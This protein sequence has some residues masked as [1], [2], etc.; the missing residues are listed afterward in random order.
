MSDDE[1]DYTFAP[2]YGDKSTGYHR[3]MISV[4]EFF[5]SNT[6]KSMLEDYAVTEM[7]C[8]DDYSYAA[9]RAKTIRRNGIT[10]F[11]LHVSQCINFHKKTKK[12]SIIVLR[13]GIHP[14]HMIYLGI[15][16]LIQM[17]VCY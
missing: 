11:I 12:D 4:V 2:I 3:H 7:G 9:P 15:S 8:F 5:Y 6:L 1:K 14:C 10:K 16:M 17:C 13:N